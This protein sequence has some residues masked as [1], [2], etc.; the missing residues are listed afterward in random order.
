MKFKELTK[1]DSDKMQTKVEIDRFLELNKK[2]L[3]II[4]NGDYS[5]LEKMAKAMLSEWGYGTKSKSK[6]TAKENVALA[7]YNHSRRIKRLTEEQLRTILKNTKEEGSDYLKLLR[8][9]KAQ[10][11]ETNVSAKLRQVLPNE[12][13]DFKALY[14]KYKKEKNSS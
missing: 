11:R 9:K 10:E 8:G 3:E 2:D 14:K 1:S 4:N 12:Q 5:D 7:L 6:P 13:K